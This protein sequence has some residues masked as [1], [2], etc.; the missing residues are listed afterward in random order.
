MAVSGLVGSGS[1]SA[2]TLSP[3]KP[4]RFDFSKMFQR[5]EAAAALAGPSRSVSKS[6]QAPRSKKLS[7][8]VDW[9]RK[10]DALRRAPQPCQWVVGLDM[11][12]TNPGL[13][14]LNPHLRVIHLFAFRNRKKET[15][16][17]TWVNCPESVFHRWLVRTTVIEEWPHPEVTFPF[18]LPR[19]AR[20]ETRI[21]SLL[22]LIGD[23]RHG[24][25]VVGLE[26][27]AFAAGPTRGDSTLKELG[28]ILRRQLCHLGHRVIEIVPSQ[29]KRI[30]CQKGDAKKKDMYRAYRELYRLPDLLPLMNIRSDDADAP[31]PRKRV[32]TT[33]VN[34]VPHPV[35][36][37]VDALAVALAVI[38]KHDAHMVPVVVGG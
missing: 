35:E 30:F 8:N 13:C 5:L 2:A 27:Y 24:A 33:P 32:R 4:A 16:S 7:L 34:E 9:A 18:S 22:G 29:V 1:V 20:Y 31:P 26:H 21:Q 37:L 23:N 38:A 12:L 10:F 11:S 6:R 15:N 17:Q 14:L 28:G 3:S 25:T 36:D 19:L